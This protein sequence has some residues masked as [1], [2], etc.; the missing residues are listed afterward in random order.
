[1]ENPQL[2]PGIMDR[3]AKSIIRIGGAARQ[4]I[5]DLEAKYCYYK[6]CNAGEFFLNVNRYVFPLPL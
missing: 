6:I 4:E 1:M 3:T 5:V 2:P